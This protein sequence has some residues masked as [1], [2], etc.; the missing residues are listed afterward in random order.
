MASSSQGQDQQKIEHL[1]SGDRSV[2]ERLFR[3]QYESLCRF[4]LSYVEKLRVAEDLVQ[5]VFFELWKDRRDLDPD[6]SLQAYLYGM[7]RHR[8]LKYLRRERVRERWAESGDRRKAVPSAAPEQAEE[9]LCF[10]E[11]RR[12]VERALQA[13][14][15]Q[16]RRIFVLSRRHDLTYS[17]IGVALDISVKTVETQMSRALKALRERLEPFS[18]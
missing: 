5:D 17:E 9:V 16:R 7:T 6:T 11:R 13:L 10:Q 3:R 14:P 12:E 1:R 18:A 15:E 4:A 2:F 8:A